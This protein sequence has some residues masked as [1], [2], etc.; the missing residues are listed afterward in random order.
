MLENY[1]PTYNATVV[2]KLLAYGGSM[3]GKDNMDE[4]AMGWVHRVTVKTLQ[5]IYVATLNKDLLTWLK[6]HMW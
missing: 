5:F 4:F 1:V 3:L 2:E 6:L